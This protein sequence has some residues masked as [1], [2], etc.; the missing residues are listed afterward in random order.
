M[1]IFPTILNTIQFWIQDNVL[2]KHD[3]DD[4]EQEIIEDVDLDN[5]SIKNLYSSC[6]NLSIPAFSR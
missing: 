3:F 2:K 6:D 4:D 5:L 1:C